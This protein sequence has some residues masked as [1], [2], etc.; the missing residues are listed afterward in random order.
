MLIG[1][2]MPGEQPLLY[3]VNTSG[4]EENFYLP[5]TLKEALWKVEFDTGQTTSA[6]LQ[7]RYPLL[8]HSSALL[9]LANK[10]S[11]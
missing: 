11:R 2:G 10:E 5:L 6:A 8:G 7:G 1:P 9:S 3:L 4:K